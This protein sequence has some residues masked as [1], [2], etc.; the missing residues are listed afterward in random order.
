MLASAQTVTLHGADGSTF[1]AKVRRAHPVSAPR[2]RYPGFSPDTL[3]LKKGTIRR[4]GSK[5]LPCDIVMY[6]DVAVTMRD[7]VK[8]YTDVFLPAQPGKYPA[9]MAWSPYGKEI[10]GQQLDDVYGRSGVPADSTSGLEKFEAPDPA[11]WCAHGYAVVN[12]DKRGAYM[13]EGNLLYWGHDD[14]LD[15]VDVIN[16]IA[17]QPWS[18]EK[19]GMAGN[20]WLCVSQWF[21]A[22]ERPK[23]LAAIAPWEGFSDHFREA[24]NRG[25]IPQPGFSE[26]IA[27]TF[28]SQYGLLEDQPWMIANNPYIN[29]YWRDK[30][31]R[32]ENITIPA[33][34]VASY[35]NPVHT[36]GTFAAYRRLSSKDKWL[37]VHD[38]N[39]WLDFY[40][41]QDDL[42]RFFDHYLKGIDNGWEK[43]PKVRLSVLNPG[44]QA[45]V[46]RVENEWPLARTQYTR[47]YLNGANQ[48]LQYNKVKKSGRQTYDSEAQGSNSLTYRLKFDKPTE[49]TGYMKLHLWVSADDYN[50]MDLAVRVMKLDAKGNPLVTM[51]TS[52][53]VA[54]G[55]LRVS[56]RKLDPTKTTEAEPVQYFTKESEELLQPGK[57]YPVE[58]EIWPMGLIFSKG[59]YLQLSV[60]AY[61]PGTVALGFGAAKQTIPVKGMT[62]D[63]NDTSVELMTIGG[64]ADQVP[65][66]A[67]VVASP[68]AHNKGRHSIYTGGS[69]DSYLYVPVIPAKR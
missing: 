55:Y 48:T 18:N 24:G 45:V 40:T 14:A 41:H 34:V 5:P 11:Y 16:W 51:G 7:G 2:V 1:Q 35:T 17:H 63:P 28:A 42:R 56:M 32:V 57:V 46:D 10:G 8:I 49:I 4:A 64:D 38:T 54:T 30:A 15:G 6:R 60:G 44:G 67:E 52:A 21:I 23:Y 3:L 19:V 65:D 50:D 12:P 43:T 26:Q 68:A 22:S 39:E 62:Y 36:H 20:S 61:S 47:L 27:E 31:P 29:D 25:G 58:I 69:Y 37:R 13:S 53:E 9:L 66:K 33:Y 59:E